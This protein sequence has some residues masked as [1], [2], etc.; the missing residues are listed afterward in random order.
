MTFC[1]YQFLLVSWKRQCPHQYFVDQ[2][3]HA[4]AFSSAQQPAENA[5]R[6]LAIQNV[7]PRA[8]RPVIYHSESNMLRESATVRSPGGR[9]L[10]K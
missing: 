5:W 4:I 6:T 9:R 7:R 3:S 8:S 2:G 1:F 10:R